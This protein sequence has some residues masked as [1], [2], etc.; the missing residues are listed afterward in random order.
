MQP[1]GIAA[2]MSPYELTARVFLDLP[3]ALTGLFSGG[4]GLIAC[5]VLIFSGP[6]HFMGPIACPDCLTKYD[7]HGDREDVAAMMSA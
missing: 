6:L 4:Y 7:E 1:T 3:G 5:F 2:V